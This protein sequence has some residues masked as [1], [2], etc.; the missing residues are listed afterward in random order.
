MSCGRAPGCRWRS[1]WPP[2]RSARSS[3]R[4]PPTGT[5]GHWPTTRGGSRDL[6]AA[7]D[8]FTAVVTQADE[9]GDVG[10]AAPGRLGLAR[11]T[12][13]EGDASGAATSLRALLDAPVDVATAVEVRVLLGR[14]LA[15]LGDTSTARAELRDA[16]GQARA[17]RVP[18]AE[19]EA[20]NALGELELSAGAQTAARA[21]FSG[22]L[23]VAERI[24]D[25]RE[26]ARARR[27][28]V[29]SVPR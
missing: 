25:A 16:L 21:W 15:A 7:R 4:P 9:D 11:I 18:L 28:V 22:A 6:A 27:G 12:L 26:V 13:A 3:W 5:A 17:A 23:S 19:V 2:A 24:G 14:A 1:P 20:G 29:A 8:A 10:A